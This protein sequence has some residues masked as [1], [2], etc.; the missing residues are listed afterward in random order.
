VE[1]HADVLDGRSRGGAYGHGMV[2]DEWAQE[3]YTVV[4]GDEPILVGPGEIC[5]FF[6]PNS[7]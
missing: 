3:D 6:C 1:G 2:L 7:L 4:E 5:F